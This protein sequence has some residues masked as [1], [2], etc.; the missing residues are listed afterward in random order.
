[1]DRITIWKIK[2]AQPKLTGQIES[3]YQ[4]VS[5]QAEKIWMWLESTMKRKDIYLIRRQ[6]VFW[7]WKT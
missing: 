6:K 1:M 5:T 2:V 4:E 3:N 7:V